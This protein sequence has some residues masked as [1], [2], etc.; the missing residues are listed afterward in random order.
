L[1]GLLNYFRAVAFHAVNCELTSRPLNELV[2]NYGGV[3]T[4]KGLYALPK[5]IATQAAVNSNSVQFALATNCIWVSSDERMGLIHGYNES[6]F[7]ECIVAA[8]GKIISNNLSKF[9]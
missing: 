6:L 3:N 1:K 8:E 9:C 7:R 2:V 4:K 5:E